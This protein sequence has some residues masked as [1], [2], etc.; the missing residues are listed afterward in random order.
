MFEEKVTVHPLFKE[1]F[2]R[3]LFFGGEDISIT[4]A[5]TSLVRLKFRLKSLKFSQRECPVQRT[6]QRFSLKS[7]LKVA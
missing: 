7:P 5:K 6:F 3:E 4:S 1:I 2:V